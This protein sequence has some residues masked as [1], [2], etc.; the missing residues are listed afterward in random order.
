M[1]RLITP[2][3]NLP[4]TSAGCYTLSS[5]VE[6]P[7][8]WSA[9]KP[10]LYDVEIRLYDGKKVV[11]EFQSH[12]GIWK[13]EIDGNVFKF[14]GQP[15]KLKGVNRHEHH[16][17]T[18]RLVDRETM[19]KDLRLMKQANINM[20]RTAHYPNSPLFYELCDRYGFYVMD[21]ANQESHDYGLGN[22][23]LGDNPEWTLAHVDRA[24]ALVQRDKN[25]PCVV[26]WSLGNE[27]GAGRNMQ[28]MADT[29]QAIDASRIIFS[30]TDLSVSAFNDPSYYTPGKFKEYAREKRDKPIFMREYA[31][32][33]GNSVGNLQEYWD[34]IEANDHVS[35]AAIWDW[36]DQGIAKKI[37]PGY[38]K[39]VENSGSY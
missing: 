7:K 32:A 39:G 34:V 13:C 11:E 17:R 9:E 26:F 31:H 15:V 24:L 18:G 22:K 25:H 2:V 30:D 37:N 10:N 5:V 8:L 23:I 35:G 33:M 27:G 1:K 6:N 19:E 12:I 28:T 36:V 38:K 20:I 29:I 21:E 4:A 16:P 3:K 14:N